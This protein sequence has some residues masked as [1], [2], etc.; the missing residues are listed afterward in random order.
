[1]PGHP[2]V[3]PLRSLT[4]FPSE[5][6]IEEGYDSDGFYDCCRDAIEEEGPQD[7]DED[8]VVAFPAGVAMNIEPQQEEVDD[9]GA[10]FV[11]IPKADLD[12]LNVGALRAE[13][14]RRGVNPK[15][16]KAELKERLIDALARSLKALP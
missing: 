1:M 16:K 7:F 14:A 4:N 9:D 2:E 8:E 15:R 13:L 6:Q 10:K 5:A 12:K 3:R 11:D